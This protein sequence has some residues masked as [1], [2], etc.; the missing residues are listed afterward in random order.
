MPRFLIGDWFISSYIS[1]D[2]RRMLYQVQKRDIFPVL[3][4]KMISS[5]FSMPLL[6][7]MDIQLD[8]AYVFGCV[9]VVRLD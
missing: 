3:F 9:Q 5:K 6:L 7:Y 1:I 2:E 4:R 8:S